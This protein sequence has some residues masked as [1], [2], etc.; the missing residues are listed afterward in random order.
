LYYPNLISVLSPLMTF[1]QYSYIVN[2]DINFHD[3]KIP[4]FATKF[5]DIKSLTTLIF[6]G[7]IPPHRMHH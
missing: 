5:H 1:R 4:S 7:I 3:I 2:F 6:I